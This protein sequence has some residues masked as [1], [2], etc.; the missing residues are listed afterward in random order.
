[1]PR[2][3]NA[4][5]RYDRY[6]PDAIELL[7]ETQRL[8]ATTQLRE[9][10]PSLVVESFLRGSS[11]LRGQFLERESLEFV[12]SPAQPV[13]VKNNPS[14]DGD[15]QGKV[16]LSSDL[17]R[18]LDEAE[19][20]TAGA[21][22]V[23][24]VLAAIWPEVQP[25]LAEL[26]H[27]GGQPVSG[28][29][30]LPPEPVP[31]P[32]GPTT[33][34]PLPALGG[35]LGQY[36][37]E[38]TEAVS[39][40]AIVGRDWELNELIAILLKY[41]KPNAVLLGDAGVGKTAIVEGLARRIREGNVPPGLRNKR[42]V[43]IPV[44]AMVAGTKYRGEFEKRMTAI[45]AQAESDDRIILF[46]DEIHM[47]VGAGVN[48][49]DQGDAADILKPALARGR[50]R[51]IGAT[52][53]SE[54]YESIEQDPALRR[55]FQEVRIDEPSDEIVATILAGAMPPMLAH[56][57]LE[58]APDIVPLVISLCRA[59]LPSRRFPDKAFDVV[60]RACAQAAI[61]GA[62]RLA[63]EH[64]RGVIARLAGIAFT[65][66]SPEFTNKLATLEES[67]KQNI[68]RQDDAIHTVARTVRLCKQRLDLKTH[69]PDGVFLFVGK[70]GVG[71]TALAHSLAETL[72]GRADAV[73]RLDMTG[74]SDSHCI[75]TLLGSPPGYV[76][77]NEEPTW[78]EQL[79][80]TPSA[81]LLLD[82]LEKA[83][84]QVM[85]V[86]LRAF[87][88]GG[89]TDAR[90][91]EHSLANVT[92]IA[93]SNAHV[94]T[95]GG[96]FGFH[97]SER[98]EHQAWVNGLQDYFPPEFLNRF[99]EIVPFDPLSVADLGIIVREKI[100]PQAERTLLEEC[101]VRL[102]I[103]NAAIRRLAE[104]AD[105]ENFGAR[106]LERVFRK[107]VLM[108][109]A[110]AALAAKSDSPSSVGIITVDRAAGGRLSVTLR[111]MDD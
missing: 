12:A 68:L 27:R 29:F 17:R 2:E 1:M 14:S 106:E 97:A 72:F 54:Y 44:G 41:H 71:K 110:D 70:S 75:N 21:V 30:D 80:K 58:A 66:D 63:P 82:E 101:N 79:K 81:V 86:F 74:Y 77:S 93:T 67:L 26:V 47:L 10:T 91:H 51:V 40:H 52:T 76:G 45:I 25:R 24:H 108:P 84:P 16:V 73:I 35:P 95:E 28:P 65:T 37:R 56:H 15:D 42:I 7:Q 19:T 100:L 34:A 109:A 64:I 11:G 36:G 83:H 104:M 6:T 92:V 57:S 94:D 50:M 105:S 23:R 49:G 38:L 3:H 61:A 59:E 4:M 46:I 39:A 20:A 87:D 78:L 98:D 8:A 53:W 90:G 13:V 18:D 89:I 102:T 99:D 111:K 62:K 60:D 48:S 103:T 88:E 33:P 107:E 85:K 9:M 22:T 31:E 96:G 55:R 43:E 5:P 32:S 69:R